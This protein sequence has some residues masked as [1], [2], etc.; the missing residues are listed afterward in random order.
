MP[1]QQQINDALARAKAAGDQE[2]V[3]EISAMVP[4]G[5]LPAAATDPGVSAGRQFDPAIGNFGQ[6][7]PGTIDFKNLPVVHNPDGSISTVRS[8]SF[9]DDN[10]L[11]VLVPTVVR[12]K[13]VSQKDAI[14]EYYKTGRHLGK[15]NDYMAADRYAQ[16]LHESEADRILGR[17][18]GQTRAA[19]RGGASAEAPA[20]GPSVDEI[21]AAL[22]RAQA[23]DDQEAVAEISA[24]LPQ[25]AAAPSLP[26]S[27]AERAAVTAPLAYGKIAS[28]LMRDPG[29][30]LSH[31]ATGLKAA[32][33]G[34]PV[35]G[36]LTDELS[37]LG[38]SW[39]PGHSY[40]AD[41]AA[42]MAPVNALPQGE[43]MGWETLGG[44]A[45]G[46]GGAS[47]APT[48]FK[49]GA[50]PFGILSGGIEG[51]GSGDNPQD[52]MRRAL[53]GMVFG[54]ATAGALST[55]LGAGRFVAKR[56]SSAPFTSIGGGGAARTLRDAMKANPEHD[57][58]SWQGP[59]ATFPPFQPVSRSVVNRGGVPAGEVM[60]TAN[61]FGDQAV[62]DALSAVDAAIPAGARAVTKEDL[63]AAG[64]ALYAKAGVSQ[65][66]QRG[67]SVI[68]P[69]VGKLKDAL[70]NEIVKKT[71]GKQASDLATLPLGSLDR[72]H[73]GIT[74]LNAK[75]RKL[76]GK[77]P[78]AY[79][80]LVDT[81]KARDLVVDAVSEINPDYKVAYDT[82]GSEAGLSRATSAG[83]KF[84]R[85]T[86]MP[87]SEIQSLPP[88]QQAAYASSAADRVKQIV[89]TAPSPKAAIASL[90]T[91]K[92]EK[93]DAAFGANAYTKLKGALE[94]A[95]KALDAQALITRGE[96]VVTGEP[97]MALGVPE[98]SSSTPGGAAFR[99][100]G[101]GASMAAGAIRNKAG[102][103]QAKDLADA[104]TTRD[105]E[106][107]RQII[108]ALTKRKN[109][110]VLRGALLGMMPGPDS[111]GARQ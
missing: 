61:K 82:Y 4:E 77:G 20:P 28:D 89:A 37:A 92:G 16:L 104:L 32:L 66:G 78:E 102:R 91:A 98:V 86:S 43:R 76:T 11:N 13:I 6:V 83:L 67:G 57:I 79:E 65:G 95:Q 99:A 9:E 74:T 106:R 107:L 69:V 54:G 27:T 34:V 111:L 1:T 56:L 49:L 58:S 85:P 52:R 38:T 46:V 12:G 103:W 39:L 88:M 75:I 53:L 36:N 41:K 45:G 51:A 60:A 62:G 105:P 19:E 59:L 30:V 80:K 94:D 25:Q 40:A 70:D 24:M 14:D 73:A 7:E 15:F 68:Y 63:A 5:G 81:R 101:S 97:R 93:L 47:A 96:K 29:A 48:A 90:N 84:D 108:D 64:R 55:L 10:G 110:M 71:M 18:P 42:Y 72:L 31:A 33:Q 50:I 21:K 100:V 22:G 3:A 17:P 26:T 8:M 109:P 44:L 35:V 23:A 2:A 87:A